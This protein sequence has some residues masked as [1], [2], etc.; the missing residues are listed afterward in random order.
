MRVAVIGGGPSWIATLEYLVTAHQFLPVEPLEVI[1]FESEDDIGGMFVRNLNPVLF[2]IFGGKPNGK[3]TA[4]L[5]NARA[6]L[7]D[8]AYVQSI[9][10]L[11]IGTIGRLY[12]LVG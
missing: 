1:L 4:P 10:W 8:T 5:D 3:L 7:L 6:S 11:N 9:L 2:Q 12:Q